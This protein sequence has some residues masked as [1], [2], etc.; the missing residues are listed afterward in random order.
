MTDPTTARGA[1]PACDKRGEMRLSGTLLSAPAFPRAQRF[2][3]ISDPLARIPHREKGATVLDHVVTDIGSHFHLVGYVGSAILVGVV[4]MLWRRHRRHQA[5]PGGETWRKLLDN[6]V[7]R[8]Y[9]LILQ[10]RTKP[11]DKVT[12]RQSDGRQLSIDRTGQ[13]SVEPAPHQREDQA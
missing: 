8:I 12:V 7:Q 5:G 13:H 3:V 10:S 1:A 9:E 2:A 11:G 6:A 4:G